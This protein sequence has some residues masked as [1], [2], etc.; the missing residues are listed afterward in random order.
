MTSYMWIDGVTA[1]DPA[2]PS[3]DW[4]VVDRYAFA[5][6]REQI[7]VGSGQENDSPKKP[8]IR[9][10]SATKDADSH[11]P[12]LAQWH[13][14]HRERRYKKVV[15]AECDL[16]FDPFLVVSLENALLVGYAISASSQLSGGDSEE[17]LT[18]EYTKLEFKFRSMDA[19]SRFN[20]FKTFR[21][22]DAQS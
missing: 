9:L 3:A 15:I 21:Y 4:I 13:V 18:F 6:E 12:A 22:D 5:L 11:T 2:T 19:G 20:R 8:V 10:A 16:G 1:G 7:V 14:D 17:R